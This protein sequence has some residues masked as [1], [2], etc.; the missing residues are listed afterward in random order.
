MYVAFQMMNFAAARAW[1]RSLPVVLGTGAVGAAERGDAPRT[2]AVGG[3]GGDARRRHE[4]AGNRDVLPARQC[5]VP[6]P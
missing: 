4:R 5:A 6:V 3:N 2:P 1:L